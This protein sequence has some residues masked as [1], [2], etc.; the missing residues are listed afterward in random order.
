MRIVFWVR[1]A[2][3]PTS[4]RARAFASRTTRIWTRSVRG[5]VKAQFG[6]R[7]SRTSSAPNDSSWNGPA[8]M[9]WPPGKRPRGPAARADT[10]PSSRSLLIV[11]S[12]LS[13]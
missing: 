6:L 1:S 10:M 3:P 7:R 4:M 9:T 13:R 5:G 2:E 11:A 12:G 8:P